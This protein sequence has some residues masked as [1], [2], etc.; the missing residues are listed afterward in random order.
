[1]AQTYRGMEQQYLDE[2]RKP[3]EH[4]KLLFGLALFHAVVQERRKYDSL[5]YNIKY[6]F[7]AGDLSISQ[8]QLKLFIDL[9]ADEALPI[10]ALRYLVGQLNYGGR[11]TDDW[12]RRTITHV[13]EDFFSVDVVKD[14]YRFD[15]SGRYHCPPRGS[16]LVDYRNYIA[17][18]P[19]HDEAEVFGL[20]ENANTTTAIKETQALFETLLALQPRSSAS[21]GQSREAVI[22]T[23]ARDIESQL[24]PNFDIE[25]ASRA[26]PVSYS[27]SLHTVLVQEL[28]RFNRLTVAVKR[29]LSELQKAVKGEVVMSAE[30]EQ[31]GDSMFNG[32]VPRLWSVVAYPS[33]KP[34]GAW[35]QDLKRR[36]QMFADWIRD[37]PPSVFWLSGFFFTQSF[38][39]GSHHFKQLRILNSTRTRLHSP[40][41]LQ[42]ARRT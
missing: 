35:V 36:L 20:H 1:V 30:L 33:L 27:N 2:S 3:E 7:T 23:L 39:T 32:Q 5:G 14:G 10:K 22:A 4:K 25:A 29:T 13:L 17:D 11:V 16:D 6:E 26:Y 42:S 21:G 37:G 31:M 40:A 18:L 9:Y 15:P 12:D 41:R 28:V 19:A 38:L 24:P 34:L 8:R